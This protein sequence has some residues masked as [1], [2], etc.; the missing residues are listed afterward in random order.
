METEGEALPDV[1]DLAVN[2]PSPAVRTA[3]VE[4]LGDEGTH[5]AVEA[6]LVEA[7]VNGEDLA[8]L[9]YNI[10]IL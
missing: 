9:T 4:A 7:V 3:A 10:M 8:D 5:M 2:D 1:V 6:L